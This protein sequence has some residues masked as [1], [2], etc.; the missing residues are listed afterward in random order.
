MPRDDNKQHPA[1]TVP[2]RGVV[3]TGNDRCLA[4]YGALNEMVIGSEEYSFN[5]L[6]A[7]TV[8]VTEPEVKPYTLNIAGLVSSPKVVG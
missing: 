4:A 7:V 5:T 8:N 3:T 2:L 1:A 6:V